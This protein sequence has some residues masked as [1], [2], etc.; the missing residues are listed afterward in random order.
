MFFP[1]LFALALTCSAVRD[2]NGYKSSYNLGNFTIAENRKTFIELNDSAMIFMKIVT[3]KGIKYLLIDDQNSND[4]GHVTQSKY[5]ELNENMIPI[6][7][8]SYK[9]TIYSNN[10]LLG[11][12][13]ISFF[14]A[15]V[16]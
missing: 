1:T 9:Y 8:V 3:D 14:V 5:I 2:L 11:D 16:F 12:S 4:Y 6:K 15:C 7:D 10:Y 13:F